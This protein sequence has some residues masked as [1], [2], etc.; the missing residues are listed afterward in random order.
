FT[1][2]LKPT[3][4]SLLAAQA[5]VEQPWTT[6]VDTTFSGHDSHSFSLPLTLDGAVRTNYDIVVRSGSKVVAKTDRSDS[7]DRLHYSIACRD[8]RT[9]TLKV[10]VLRRSGPPGP[11]TVKATY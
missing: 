2:L 8:Q 9:E 7:N 5:D 6:H 3:T 10:Q 1:S 4:G 11:Y